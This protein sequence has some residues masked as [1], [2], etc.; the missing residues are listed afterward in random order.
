MS[1]R[2][3]ITAGECSITGKRIWV[4]SP[5]LAPPDTNGDELG[6]YV[7]TI[8]IGEKERW[9]YE[10]SGGTGQVVADRAGLIKAHALLLSCVNESGTR[11]F[12]DI[13]QAEQ[14]PCP[15]G[16]RA[17]SVFL[18]LNSTSDEQ[19]DEAVKNS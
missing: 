18:Q 1:G 4:P 9:Q 14:L 3:V 10:N 6:F 7:K 11:I 12:S 17:Y 19:V 16:E 15:V 8:S 2:R 5:E 13:S